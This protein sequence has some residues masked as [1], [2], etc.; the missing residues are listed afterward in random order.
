MYLKAI[1]VKDWYIGPD[2]YGKSIYIALDP[3]VIYETTETWD[4]LWGP[5]SSV[6]WTSFEALTNV[7]YL[8]ERYIKKHKIKKLDVL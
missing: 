8:V 1:A 2:K 6:A 4:V 5:K 3:T 7:E